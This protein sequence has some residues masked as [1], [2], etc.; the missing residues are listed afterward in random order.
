M[1]LRSFHLFLFAF[2]SL[3]ATPNKLIVPGHSLGNIALGASPETLEQLGKPATSDAAMQKAWATWYGKPTASHLPPT[4]LDVY[5]AAT[6]PDM[7]KTIQMVRATSSW[8][9]TSTGLHNGSTLASIRHAYSSLSLTTSYAPTPKA[10][11][12][13]IYDNAKAGIAFEMDGKAATSHCVA[14]ILH[15]PGKATASTYM[16]MTQYLQLINQRAAK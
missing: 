3:A 6:G 9:R 16:A 15:L 13:Y 10:S 2:L 4:Q 5:T 12:H 1:R 11:P 7:R 14:I 8:F